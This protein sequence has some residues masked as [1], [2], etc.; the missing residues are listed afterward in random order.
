MTPAALPSS[1]SPQRRRRRL[2]IKVVSVLLATFALGIWA[3]SLVVHR[4][5]SVRWED[6]QSRKSES[7]S[8]VSARW[9]TRTMFIQVPNADHSGNAWVD[10]LRAYDSLASVPKSEMDLV[11][12]AVEGQASAQDLSKADEVLDRCAGFLQLVRTGAGRAFAM[13]PWSLDEPL[14]DDLNSLKGARFAG[15]LMRRSMQIRLKAGD[16]TGMEHE[17]SFCMRAA[18]DMMN[19][20]S[21]IHL[22]IGHGMAIGV[23]HELRAALT[24]PDCDSS[25]AGRIMDLAEWADT[26]LPRYSEVIEAERLLALAGLE[27]MPE[28]DTWKTSLALWR[29]AGSFR[30]MVCCAAEA[31]DRL[32]IEIRSHEGLPWLQAQAAYGK[33]LD[34]NS[35]PGV[36]VIELLKPAL[37]AGENSHRQVQARLRLIAAAASVRSGRSRGGAGWRADPFDLARLRFRDSEAETEIWSVWTDSAESGSGDWEKPDE[38]GGDCRLTVRR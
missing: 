16:F 6:Y 34:S 23:T 35:D 31:Y 30:L 29:N 38:N 15:R 1:P 37:S 7:K 5:A 4:K 22:L 2:A 17:G 13:P 14:P 33:N 3:M 11:A 32:L 9:G 27:R 8:R 12:S 10:Y 26:S 36:L 28:R 19:G 20:P 24:S 18:I 21:L 25:T